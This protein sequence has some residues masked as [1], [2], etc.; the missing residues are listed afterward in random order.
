LN[1]KEIGEVLYL[2]HC[3]I[4]LRDQDTNKIGAEVF[5]ELSN[6]VLQEIGEDK[7]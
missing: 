6:V 2:E 4:W 5:Q 3:F 1:S 7:I